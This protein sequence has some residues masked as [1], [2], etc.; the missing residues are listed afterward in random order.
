MKQSDTAQVIVTGCASAIDPE[1]FSSL[2]K[3][4]L[5][6]PDKT[7]VPKL[8]QQILGLPPQPAHTSY[9]ARFGKGFHSRV[10]IKIQDG[11][12][13]A[14]S[15]CIV[16][17]ARGPL[18]SKDGDEVLQE[19]RLAERSGV[20]E[21]VLTGINLGKYEGLARLLEDALLVT[22]TLRI[23]LSS[24]EPAD[25]GEDLIELMAASDG[26]ICRH[27]HL[28]L[29]SGCEHTLQ[30]MGR[31]YTARDFENLVGNLRASMPSIALTTDVI[32]GFPGELDE[33][34]EESLGFCRRMGFSK[35]HVFRYSRRPNTPAAARSDQID[36]AVISVRAQ[37]LRALADTLRCR[38]ALDRVGQEELLLVE[39]GGTITSESYFT[40]LQG[41][42][43][44][45]AS[46]SPGKLVPARFIA[47]DNDQLIFEAIP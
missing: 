16:H 5:V 41:Q 21:A 7:R 30:Q 3:R 45:D 8:A 10:G 34:F 18:W 40:C 11:C 22:S 13:N 24:I 46:I 32:A 20:C 1:V 29:Q 27:L 33:H 38:D 47:A 44:G 28:P 31:T 23:R 39:E 9:A 2:S 4:I 12:D 26:R 17:V 25:I 19:L 37:K 15:Y 35:I 14:C 42:G 36:P 6:E 43:G